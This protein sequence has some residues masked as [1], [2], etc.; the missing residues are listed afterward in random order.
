MH[1]DHRI[2]PRVASLG[3]DVP[4]QRI[5]GVAVT[6]ARGGADDG[7]RDD[8]G[9]RGEG[10]AC[11]VSAS[12]VID[13]YFVL[14]GVFLKHL[15]ELPEHQA[16]RGSLVEYRNADI[17]QSETS[18]GGRAGPRAKAIGRNSLEPRV[19]TRP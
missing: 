15:A 8:I 4:N 19:I 16:N 13:D 18:L 6:L 17:Q 2:A 5:E 7:E 11:P 1:D 12:V 9:I 14:P 10:L 3:G